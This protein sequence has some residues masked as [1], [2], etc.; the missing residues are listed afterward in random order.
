[1]PVRARAWLAALAVSACSAAGSPLYAQNV[2]VGYTILATDH[3]L[4][5]SPLQGGRAVLSRPFGD[6]SLAMRAG[7]EAMRGQASRNGSPCAGLIL[8][9]PAC[10]VQPLRDDGRLYGGTLGA[11]LRV[12]GRPHVTLSVGVDLGLAK[13]TMNTHATAGS[14]GLAADEMLWNGALNLDAAWYPSLTRRVG[15]IGS[16]GVRSFTQLS[17]GHVLDGYEPFQDGMTGR[18]AMIGLAWRVR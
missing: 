17:Q 16:V 11:A 3:Q 6:S 18:Q 10:A 8:P 13:A 9:I 2:S 14:S 12:V 4:L 7:V 5:G 15:V 1:M